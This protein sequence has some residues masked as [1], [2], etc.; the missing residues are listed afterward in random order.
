MSGF[1]N[2]N[3]NVNAGDFLSLF[4]KLYYFLENKLIK[5]ES[6]EEL[7][8]DELVDIYSN[9]KVFL[10]GLEYVK[11]SLNDIA[12]SMRNLTFVYDEYYNFMSI[13]N[14]IDYIVD[15]AGRYIKNSSFVL[16][17][18]SDFNNLME[19]RNNSD[20]DALYEKF[21]IILDEQEDYF[22]TEIFDG[23][24]EYDKLIVKVTNILG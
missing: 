5:I 13:K 15:D 16:T 4:K 18:F 1:I 7:S 3:A 24:D 9:D 2:A 11:T 8:F 17:V 19:N 6:R 23:T 14:M 20:Y 12:L 21:D 10:S 22:Y